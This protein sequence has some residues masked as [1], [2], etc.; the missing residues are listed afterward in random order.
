MEL[1][2]FNIF[3]LKIESI[4]VDIKLSNKLKLVVDNNKSTFSFLVV[5]VFK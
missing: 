5:E 3:S 4:L 2:L 1:I